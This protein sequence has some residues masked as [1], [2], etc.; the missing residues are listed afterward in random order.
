MK[1]MITATLKYF[2]GL[3]VYWVHYSGKALTIHQ[4]EALLTKN[5][6]GKTSRKELNRY[7]IIENFSCVKVVGEK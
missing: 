5:T 4:C 7:F 1:Y 6:L 2:G 3:P